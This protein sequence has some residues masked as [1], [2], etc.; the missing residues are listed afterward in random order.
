M[1]SITRPR[2]KIKVLFANLN[3][4]REGKTLDKKDQV[5]RMKS[6]GMKNF[7]GLVFLMQNLHNLENS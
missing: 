3:K 5:E 2:Q 6:F 7:G 4:R 1:L